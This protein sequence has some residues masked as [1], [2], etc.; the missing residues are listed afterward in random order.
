MPLARLVLLLLVVRAGTALASDA[1]PVAVGDV[2]GTSARLHVWAAG[3]GPV[4]VTVVPDGA[5]ASTRSLQPD[6]E[7]IARTTLRGLVPGR[8]H[9]Y[10]VESEGHLVTGEFVTPPPP[11]D[12]APVRLVWSGDLGARGHCGA[13]RYGV[14]DTMRRQRPDLFLFVGDTVYADHPCRALP[15]AAAAATTFEEFA[16][17]HR[18][19]LADPAVQAFLRRTSVTAIWDD[20]EVRGNFAG[21]R[22]PLMPVGRAAFLAS[23]PVAT[24]P[25]DP[26][27]LYRSRRWGGLLE[28]FVLDTRQYRSSNWAPDGPDKTMLGAAQ[29]RWLVDAVTASTAVWK[30]V[31]SSVP[32]SL[33]KGWPV[34]D[35]WAPR[36][37]LG[38][39]TG[40]ARERDAILALLQAAGVQNLVV[41]A[42]DVHFATAVAHTPAPGF[43]VWEL[44]AGPIA[45]G[46]KD[47]WCPAPGLNSTVLFAHGGE[48]TFGEVQ[49]YAHGLDVRLFAGDGRLLWRRWLPA[50]RRSGNDRQDTEP[51]GV[52]SGWGASA[53]RRGATVSDPIT[54]SNRPRQSRLA[55]ARARS[56]VRMLRDMRGPGDGA[57]RQRHLGPHRVSLRRPRSRWHRA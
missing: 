1:V 35:S 19:N 36:N 37:V 16:A 9:R 43:R 40:F 57:P 8:R 33:P 31:V 51:C 39:R 32:L 18:R 4:S 6:A 42:A 7:L 17:R 53:C 11:G 2:T 14:F 26:T 15:G 22:Q 56:Q 45:A 20:H 29:R 34:S 52:R 28:I 38:Y 50:A 48:A 46:T 27:R 30:V 55:G 21:S 3:P 12:P 49:V 23:W 5:G 24:P 25:G 41:L 13:R 10:R 47:P 44:V 54:P